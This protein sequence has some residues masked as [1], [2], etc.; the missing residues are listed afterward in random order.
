M[1][2]DANEIIAQEFDENGVAPPTTRGSLA[3]YLLS[4]VAIGMLRE[5]HHPAHE[6]QPGALY[7][8]YRNRRHPNGPG[9]ATPDS[10]LAAREFA[11]EAAVR[12]ALHYM[13][14]AS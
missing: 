2:I 3:G 8:E 1:P 9:S 4:R 12:L 13:K 10:K 5:L 7:G 11:L 14:E 6:E